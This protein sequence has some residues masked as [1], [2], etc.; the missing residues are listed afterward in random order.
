M[1]LSLVKN[2]QELRLLLFVVK[3]V[4]THGYNEAR[5]EL[6][7]K[8][9]WIRNGCSAYFTHDSPHFGVST[10]RASKAK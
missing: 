5:S 7:R 10:F 9:L 6:C 4:A 1:A 3:Q 2:L 8:P